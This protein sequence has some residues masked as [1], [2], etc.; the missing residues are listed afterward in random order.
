MA[1]A[2]PQPQ[3]ETLPAV[4]KEGA[5]IDSELANMFAADSRAGM[6]S[7]DQDSFAIPFLSVLQAL[8]PQLDESDAK[9]VD[10]AKAG[11][12]YENVTNQLIDGK[13]GAIVIPCHYRR[14]FLRWGPRGG[15]GAGFK[16]ELTPEQVAAMR[17]SKQIVEVDGRLFVPMPDGTVN[18]K[19]CD[20]IVD[21][22]NHYVLLVNESTGAAVTAL[23]SLRSTQIKKSKALMS[24]LAAV[25]VKGPQGDVQPPTFANLVRVCTVQEKND[26]GNWHGV[27]FAVEGRVYNAT[28]YKQARDFYETVKK[29]AVEVRYEEPL[30]E[31]GGAGN[32]GGA[33]RPAP[34]QDDNRF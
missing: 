26:E 30:D 14:V 20:R 7:A 32:A 8:S 29:G 22:R 6:E 17:Q 3:K 21:T 19:R 10:G 2:K 16:G 28:L 24:A 18:E 5:L 4:R 34:N 1:S 31:A 12:L 9:F 25:R 27:K 33:R 11:M 15:E 13:D 23:L